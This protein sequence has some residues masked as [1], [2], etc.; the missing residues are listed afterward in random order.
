MSDYI[1][2]D[3]LFDQMCQSILTSDF[4]ISWA[5]KY[6]VREKVQEAI[7]DISNELEAWGV[8]IIKNEEGMLI[9]DMPEPVQTR[10][11]YSCPQCAVNV[12]GKAGLHLICGDCQVDFVVID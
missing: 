5:D 11:K 3:S 1:T 12:W 2:K 9:I 6:P 4:R 10:Q 7:E 8:D